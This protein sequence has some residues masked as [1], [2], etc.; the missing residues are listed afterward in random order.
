MFSHGTPGVIELLAPR[1]RPRVGPLSTSQAQFVAHV[2]GRAE[3]QRP[4][5]GDAAR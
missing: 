2:V 5:D 3:R 1:K 4:R